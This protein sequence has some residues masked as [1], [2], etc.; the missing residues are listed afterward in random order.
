MEIANSS[1]AKRRTILQLECISLADDFSARCFKMLMLLQLSDRYDKPS[2]TPPSKVGARLKTVFTT[3]IRRD[4][5]CITTS[6]DGFAAYIGLL[7]R[8][9]PKRMSSYTEIAWKICL[10][11][12]PSRPT[13]TNT[14]VSMKS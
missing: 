11:D 8:Y 1:V 6:L 3:V 9:E 7:E 14:F 13:L 5:L 12:I 2:T 4:A 10:S